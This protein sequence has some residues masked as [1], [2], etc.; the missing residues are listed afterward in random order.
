[1]VKNTMLKYSGA[2][3]Q[4]P[5]SADPCLPGNNTWGYDLFSDYKQW[6]N[7]GEKLSEMGSVNEINIQSFLCIICI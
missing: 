3:R 4:N 1:M 5:K 7:K 6:L 2:Q